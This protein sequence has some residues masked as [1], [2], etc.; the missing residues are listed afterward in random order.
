MALIERKP[1]PLVHILSVIGAL[2]LLSGTVGAQAGRRSP[3]ESGVKALTV[4]VI[5][6]SAPG[7]LDQLV[8]TRDQ[9]ELYDGGVAQQIQYF[10]PDYSPAKIVV[11]VDNSERL[12]A[13][14]GDMTRAVKA[15]VANLYEGDQMMII[16]YDEQ[17]E[18]IEDFTSEAKKLEAATALFRKKGAPRLLDAI[19]ATIHD[20]F[21]LQVGVTKRILILISDGYDWESRTPF[22]TVITHLEQENIVTYVL[23]A[24][25][26]TYGASR[27]RALK[28]V[29]LIKK[30]TKGTGGR[31]FPLSKVQRAAREILQEVSER[32]YQLTYRPKGVDPLTTRRLL[33]VANDPR[34]R[35][36]TK[37]EQPGVRF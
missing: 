11:L 35:L 28:P 26:R 19:E 18:I 33:V 9:L 25:D 10:R 16:G 32:W 31:I 22:K 34:I 24:P 29:A 14:I 4:P 21:R 27:R 7:P 17:P 2:T 15:L 30:L 5:I 20:V 3:S 1:H 23:Q 6:E 13:T 12:P 36:R 37:L 8:L